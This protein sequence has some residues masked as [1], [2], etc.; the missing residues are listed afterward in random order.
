MSQQDNG[1]C[2]YALKGLQFHYGRIRDRTLMAQNGRRGYHPD[3][4]RVG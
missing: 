2:L 4:D 1:M 3:H